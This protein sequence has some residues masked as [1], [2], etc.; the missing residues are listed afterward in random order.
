MP[1]YK[2]HL[3]IKPVISAEKNLDFE[4]CTIIRLTAN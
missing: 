2:L 3:E 4:M 1:L